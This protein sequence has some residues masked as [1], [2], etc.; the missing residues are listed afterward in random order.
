VAAGADE[1]QATYAFRGRVSM[2][3]TDV[4]LAGASPTDLFKG[5]LRRER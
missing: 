4:R 2:G 3:D 5:T 1:A